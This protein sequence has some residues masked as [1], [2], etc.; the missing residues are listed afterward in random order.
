MSSIDSFFGPK[1]PPLPSTASVAQ[2]VQY[3]SRPVTNFLNGLPSFSVFSWPTPESNVT[4][5]PAT[6]GFNLNSASSRL[7]IKD[8]GSGNTGWFPI[9]YGD[10]CGGGP[11]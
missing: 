8:T 9:C 1:V 10:T 11:T 4:A 2:E 3:W 7:W 5:M 6:L